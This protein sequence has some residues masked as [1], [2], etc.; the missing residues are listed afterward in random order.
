M[1][2]IQTTPM[3]RRDTDDYYTIFLAS[4]GDVDKYRAAADEVVKSIDNR[5]HPRT[6]FSLFMWEKHMVA[7]VS[8]NIQRDIFENARRRW[9]RK[10]ITYT[11]GTKEDYWLGNPCD[12]LVFILWSKV[13]EGTK[14]EYKNYIA[15]Y[16]RIINETQNNNRQSR[17]L[18][19]VIG[20]RIPPDKAG[21]VA[22]LN[23]FLQKHQKK[24]KEISPVRLSVKN[25]DAYKLALNDALLDFL[26]EEVL[27]DKTTKRAILPSNVPPYP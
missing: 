27:V 1:T 10:I 26:D 9:D 3:K 15:E 12:I 20:A 13:G 8:D 17:F 22:D 18:G 6:K 24:W 19:C 23:K 5:F 4:P 14:K 16:S 21:G 11:N 25:V 7:G 2:E